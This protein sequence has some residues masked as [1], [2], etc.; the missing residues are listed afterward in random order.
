MLWRV[1]LRNYFRNFPKPPWCWALLLSSWCW[2]CRDWP[3]PWLQCFLHACWD[4]C[5]PIFFRHLSRPFGHFLG[6]IVVIKYT[7][8]AA[9]SVFCIPVTGHFQG[10]LPSYGRAQVAS[11]HR[12]HGSCHDRFAQGGRSPCMS[13]ANMRWKQKIGQKHW[14]TDMSSVFDK[15]YNP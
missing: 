15:L 11:C 2:P 4:R 3:H 14:S 12:S 5:W 7:P 6:I 9:R 13:V 10:C 1:S 8:I